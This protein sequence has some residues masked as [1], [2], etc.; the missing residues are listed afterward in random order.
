MSLV[1]KP[2]MTEKKI[3]ANRRNGGLSQGPVTAEGKERIGAAQLRHGFYAQAQEAALRSSGR[4][5]GRTSRNCSQ[6]LCEEFTPAGTLQE[7][8]VNRLARVLWLME[9]ADRSLEG[10]ALRRARS[11][12]A[13]TRQPP[14]RPHDAAEDD[15]GNSALARPLRGVLALRH[16]PRGPGSHE[17]T[18]SGGGRGRNG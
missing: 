9:R 3:A 18:A 2:T 1:K 13:W 5:P 4:G 8:L 7:K 16:P 17:E 11:A 6:G 12:D 14:A 10:D 15:G